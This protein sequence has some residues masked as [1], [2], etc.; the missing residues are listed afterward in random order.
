MTK[1]IQGPLSAIVGL[2]IV[3]SACTAVPDMPPETVTTTAP[4]ADSRASGSQ[5]PGEITWE[6]ETDPL[7]DGRDAADDPAIWVDPADPARSVIIGTN[8]KG[9]DGLVV[10]D[11]AGGELQAIGGAAMNNVDLRPR[12]IV[13]GREMILVVAST[14][15]DRSLELFALDPGS[16]EL[17]GA[18]ASLET[19]LRASGLCLYQAADDVVHAFAT[20]GNG[21]VQQWRITA[22]SDGLDGELVRELEF[23]SHLEGCV[24][25]DVTATFYLSEETRGIWRMSADPA[26]AD[27]REL[28]DTIGAAGRLEADLEGLAI[29][30][31]DGERRFLV[32]SSQG[33]DR[34]VVYRL[35]GDAAPDV[36]GDF[37]IEAPDGADD[38]T[39]T[40][41]ID[42]TLLAVGPA[43]FDRGMLVV[44]D[45]ENEQPDGGEAN[46]NFKVIPWAVVEDRLGMP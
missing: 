43:P 7:P 12:V 11:L 1:W 3:A 18:G 37:T 34:F 26:A 10:Y 27:D 33:D 29:A 46:Q 35:N 41:G 44:Q 21:D 42:L 14:I 9:Q 13:D 8:K 20:G 6:V 15:E 39:H 5:A 2:A 25:D 45:D 40:D 28:L 30:A 31:Y 22:G 17:S 19:G 16:R 23:D 32:A 38:V 36:V 24:V 4:S